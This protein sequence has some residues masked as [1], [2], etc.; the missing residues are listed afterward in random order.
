MTILSIDQIIMSKPGSFALR[1]ILLLMT[2]IAGGPK[3]P[4]QG[5]SSESIT[6]A[7]CYIGRLGSGLA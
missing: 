6:Q 7:N 5:V 3:P 1:P 2:L 4:Q